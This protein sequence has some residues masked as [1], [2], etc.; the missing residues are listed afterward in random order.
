MIELESA[1]CLVELCVSSSFGILLALSLVELRVLSALE[2]CRRVMFCLLL[3]MDF[4]F[5]YFL[6]DIYISNGSCPPIGFVELARD[7]LSCFCIFLNFWNFKN[8]WNS[9][10]ESES[11]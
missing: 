3:M 6:N 1:L 10:S 4:F 8:C 7:L 2:S 9:S 5:P 11:S